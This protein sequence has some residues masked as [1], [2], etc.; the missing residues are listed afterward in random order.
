MRLI[1][2]A[3]GAHRSVV[4]LTNSGFRRYEQRCLIRCAQ[5]CSSRPSAPHPS[6]DAARAQRLAG[7]RQRREQRCR[8]TQDGVPL[9]PGRTQ[10]PH[11]DKPPAP[12]TQN[13]PVAPPRHHRARR[14]GSSSRRRS[15][16]F[17]ARCQLAE[18]DRMPSSVVA[19]ARHDNPLTEAARRTPIGQSGAAHFTNR[20]DPAHNAQLTIGRS[21][22]AEAPINR[23]Q[24][25]SSPPA[26]AA[27]VHRVARLRY[28]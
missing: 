24:P 28:A 22:S 20:H 23:R 6:E 27:S 3:E 10:R 17:S 1:V 13:T 4:M 9:R 11:A 16:L 15:P 5:R 7:R 18:H 26:H 19:Y 25:C 12:V 2:M 21:P 14:A 8:D